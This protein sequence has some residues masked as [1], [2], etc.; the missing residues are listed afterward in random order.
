MRKNYLLVCLATS[1]FW[2]SCK[3]EAGSNNKTSASLTGSYKGNVTVTMTIPPNIVTTNVIDDHVISFSSGSGN[4]LSMSTQLIQS[5]TATISGN[6]LTLQ[7]HTVNSN[8][9]FFTVEYGTGT[10]QDN[11]FTFDFHQ[12]IIVLPITCGTEVVNG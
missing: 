9:T 2:G 3:K 7:K 4:T 1:I 5:T 6:T 11:T 10:F 8:S 12:D